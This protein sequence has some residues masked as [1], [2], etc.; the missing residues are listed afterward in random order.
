M[1]I[2]APLV[3]Y[4]TLVCTLLN[5]SAW[6]Q[7]STPPPSLP[8]TTRYDSLRRVYQA[9]HLRRI[10]DPALG[11]VPTE[12][13]STTRQQFGQSAASQQSA[14][15]GSSRGAAATS[16]VQLGIFIPNGSYSLDKRT[17]WAAETNKPVDLVPVGQNDVVSRT[18]FWIPNATGSCLAEVI[19]STLPDPNSTPDNHA[20]R[21]GEDDEAV[22]DIR[23]LR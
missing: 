14:R 17:W 12:R 19:S 10:R 16:Y 1:P 23:V 6:A 4:T 18:I 22:A 3:V 13:L 5:F 2:S 21:P 9:E 11:R 7:V 20:A 8:S 15:S